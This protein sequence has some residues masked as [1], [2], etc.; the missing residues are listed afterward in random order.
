M[1]YSRI[2]I[3][4]MSALGDV[5]MTLPC[6][7]VLRTSYPSAHIA[8]LVNKSNAPLL[9][10]NPLLN[11]VIPFDRQ[12]FSN[13]LNWLDLIKVTRHL[14]KQNFDL[15]I[16]FQ[17]LFKSSF[18]TYATHAPIRVGSG[19][20]R[21]GSAIF[22]THRVD[23]RRANY[24]GVDW[25]LQFLKTIPGIQLAKEIPIQFSFP[26]FSFARNS[27]ADKLRSAG[28]K[29][30]FSF[31]AV[32]PGARWKT[33]EWLLER[34]AELADKITKESGLPTVLIGGKED[35][36]KGQIVQSLQKN[37]SVNMI[38]NTN[39]PELALLLKQAKV[40]VTND[41]GPMHL[42]YALGTPVI[43]IHGPTDS[44][45][46]GP[47]GTHHIVIKVDVP[48]GPCFKK[49]CPGYG[50]VCMKNITADMVYAKVSAYL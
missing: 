32:V 17:G 49:I 43:A 39:L 15:V 18:L 48:C 28:L 22:Y 10:G 8:W 45:L 21:E 11:E 36:E 46:T 44:R 31:V 5:I 37:K 3:V 6:L 41:T 2:L 29:E 19:E 30:S 23:I 13:P 14:R 47:Y 7:S 35:I 27:L 9:Q 34:F 40:L 1:S 20:N 25:Q 4:R 42:G 38:G 26:D 24:H 33:K 50:H 12:H 16:D